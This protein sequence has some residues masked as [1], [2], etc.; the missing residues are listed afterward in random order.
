MK[1][2]LML[3]V[4]YGLLIFS[5]VAQQ[6]KKITILHTNDMHSR[7]MGYAPELS[8]T[9]LTTNDDKTIGGFA[10][11][12]A[13][14][15]NETSSGE[16]TTL[17]L[18]AGDFLMGTLFQSLEPSTG[19][20]LRLMKEMGYDAVCIGN[21]EFDFGPEKLAE[22]LN[23]SAR[24]GSIPPVLMSNA[25][26]SAE[27]SADDELEKLFSNNTLRRKLVITKDGI[28][29]GFFSL[30]G[31][32]ADDNAAYAPPVT[33]SKQ[34]PAARK[35]VQELKAEGCDIIICLSHS[36]VSTGKTGEWTGEDVELAAKVKGI[37]VII[38]G[39]T[40][41]RIDK[42]IT[43]NGTTIVQAGEYGQNVGKLSMTLTGGKIKADSY[44]LIPVD[45]RIAGDPEVNA[46]IEEQKENL[47]KMIL[48]PLGMD[49]KKPVAESDF[50][51]ECNEQGDIEG[52]NLG[53]LVA[54][55]IHS[56]VNRHVK[57]GTDLSMVAVGVIRDRIVPGLQ[58][59]PDVFRIMSMGNGN[60]NLPGYPLS[61]LYVTGRELKGILEIMYI[62]G[63]STPANYCYYAGIKVDYDPGMG[64]LKKIRNISIVGSDGST[65]AVDISKEN[66]TLYSIV[67]NSYMLEYVSIIKKLSKG[68]VKVVPKDGSGNVITDMKASI[69]DFDQ[70]RDGI[71]EGK[72]WIAIIEYLSSMKDTNGNGIPDI[73]LKYQKAIKSFTLV[74]GK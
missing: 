7:L 4:F 73:D 19:F 18:D 65:K 22:I 40:H 39:H 66:K 8:Y 14:I 67:A 1:K 56:Y 54:D 70:I 23:S 20:Q 50:L 30:M 44:S 41:T 33:F 32:V 74:K 2:A 49:Y 6:G 31:V 21:H 55:A 58:T 35:L 71:Q 36:G 27:E 68:L 15:K 53:P 69:M 38:S 37:D 10:R 43:V 59:A 42:P 11:I 9:P 60:D 45:D 13:V 62:A 48:N 3:F 17:V 57:G 5:S 51:L 72:E 34:L 25:V 64:L 46:R 52:S 47:T 26:F 24:G 28:K 16:G 61:R 29:F 12:A 63:K